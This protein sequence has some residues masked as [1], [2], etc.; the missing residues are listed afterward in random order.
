MPRTGSM[1]TSPPTPWGLL[2]PRMRLLGYS[3]T[4]PLDWLSA[5]LADDAACEM[6]WNE[7]AN[8]RVLCDHICETVYDGVLLHGDSVD[9]IL[10]QIDAIRKETCSQIPVFVVGSENDCHLAAVCHEAGAD[11]FIA[12]DQMT[13]RELVWRLARSA[14]RRRAIEENDRLLSLEQQR[15]SIEQD[16]VRRLAAEQRAIVRLLG[17]D[18]ALPMDETDDWLEMLLN[19]LLTTYVVMRSQNLGD[20]ME[21]FLQRT[22]SAEVSKVRLARAFMNVVDRALENIGTSSA[23]HVYN[24]ANLLLLEMILKMDD[25]PTESA[26]NHGT[27]TNPNRLPSQP[28]GSSETG[29]LP[30]MRRAA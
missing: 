23:R 9:Q 29:T 1:E 18:A 2:P 7:C 17:V 24:R 13:I 26:T 4:L 28:L 8:F 25:Q 14:E 6:E 27:P 12:A 11:G 19:D 5:A 10:T 20:E 15:R 21:R 16:E 30:Q 22:R 3:E